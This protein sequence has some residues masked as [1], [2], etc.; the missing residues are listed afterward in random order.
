MNLQAASANSLSS[1][2][3]AGANGCVIFRPSVIQ[4][5]SFLADYKTMPRTGF[6]FP[7]KIT[8]AG[9]LIIILSIMTCSERGLVL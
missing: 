3:N 9:E 7:G 2:Y 5:V 8:D 4:E 6:A 1:V